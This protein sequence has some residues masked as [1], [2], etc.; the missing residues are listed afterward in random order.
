MTL[1]EMPTRVTEFLAFDA[2]TDSPTLQ[3]ANDYIG[4]D[5][6]ECHYQSRD[7]ADAQRHESR[8]VRG[9]IISLLR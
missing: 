6:G 4:Y 3:A 8:L 9:L 1:I 2:C 5:L 7:A